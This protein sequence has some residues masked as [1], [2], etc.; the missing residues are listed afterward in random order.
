MRH[1]LVHAAPVVCTASEQATKKLSNRNLSAG[2]APGAWDV[3]IQRD[4]VEREEAFGLSIVP[5]VSR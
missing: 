4:G 1:G 3:H 2:A 5:L